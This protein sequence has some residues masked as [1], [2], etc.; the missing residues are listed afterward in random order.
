MHSLMSMDHINSFIIDPM[1][2]CTHR[3]P[4][5]RTSY[6]F[7]FFSSSFYSWP[8]RLLLR[9]YPTCTS[10]VFCLKKCFHMPLVFIVFFVNVFISK[11]EK[12]N[13]IK[14]ST[15]HNGNHLP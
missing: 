10:L 15:G 13:V 4:A 6:N 5:C 14:Q 1:N 2:I 8:L 12:K 7:L 3:P 9:F 11:K